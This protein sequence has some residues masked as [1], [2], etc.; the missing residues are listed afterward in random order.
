MFSKLLNDLENQLRVMLDFLN[1]KY[2]D[3]DIQCVLH[4]KEGNF[5]RKARKWT[6]VNSIVELF[7]PQLQTKIN[8][9]IIEVAWILKHKYNI[10]WQSYVNV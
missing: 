9:S 6:K 10:D 8:T 2:T 4:N 7:P 5:H 3:N 1:W